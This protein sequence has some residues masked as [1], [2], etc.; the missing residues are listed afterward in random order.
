MGPGDL[1]KQTC[2]RNGRKHYRFPFPL[3]R[4]FPWTKPT[5][6]QTFRV[7]QVPKDPCD[8]GRSALRFSCAWP[9][10]LAPARQ[11]ASGEMEIKPPA[12][13]VGAWRRAKV[14]GYEIPKGPSRRRGH[15]AGAPKLGR[16]G[17][18][19]VMLISRAGVRSK[20]ASRRPHLHPVLPSACSPTRRGRPGRCRCSSSW[21]LQVRW[22]AAQPAALGLP[23]RPAGTRP[24]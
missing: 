10:R 7:A 1:L 14:D 19:L 6:P 3:R 24:S 11:M 5:R 18:A 16:A 20:C 13:L 12:A 2:N 22:S 17:L 9:R 15:H 21:C 4:P 23:P 8:N